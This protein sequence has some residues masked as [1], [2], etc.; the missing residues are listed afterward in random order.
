MKLPTEYAWLA[1][2]PG[3]PQILEFIKI[4]GVKETPG[5]RSTAEILSWAKE[6]GVQKVYRADSIPWCG[7]EVG[8]VMKRA[9]FA[10]PKT[11]LWALSWAQM[12]NDVDG[13]PVLGDVLTFN[14]TGGGHVGL[15]VGE[16]TEAYHV[17]AGN[18]SDESCIARIAKSRLYRARRPDYKES[19][20]S[21][22]R[23]IQLAANG[24][25]SRN[26]SQY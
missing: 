11:L 10:L 22:L 15:Y 24:G 13:H 14:R 8:V 19:Y 1:D 2:E 26:I 12:Y 3:P 25:L 9:G 6:I 17:A 18:Q 21:V 23:R 4:Y 5:P 7:L 16:D 20:A